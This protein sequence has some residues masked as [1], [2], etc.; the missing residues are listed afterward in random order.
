[1]STATDHSALV[2]RAVLEV[3]GHP[4]YRGAYLPAW[5]ISEATGMPLT[6]SV[7]GRTLQSLAAQGR[8]ERRRRNAKQME[9]RLA[10]PS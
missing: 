10:P 2:S 9:W 1:V 4:R 6:P 7:L 5:R 8:V 3:L